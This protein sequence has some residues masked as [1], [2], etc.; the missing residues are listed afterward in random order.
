MSK[1]AKTSAVVLALLLASAARAQESRPAVSLERVQATFRSADRD[2]DRSITP[3]EAS[4]AGIPIR[5]FVRH[6]A[7]RDRRLS[8]DE[9]LLYYRYLLV[10]AGRSVSVSLETEASRIEGGRQKRPQPAGPKPRSSG[11][12]DAGTRAPEPGAPPNEVKP[13]DQ[14]DSGLLSTNERLRQARA[15]L[16]S[17][18]RTP[19]RPSGSGADGLAAERLRQRS[20]ELR[21]QAPAPDALAAG[22]AD[23]PYSRSLAVIQR[24]VNGGL[25]STQEARHFHEVLAAG[26]NLDDPGRA[27]IL[28]A[29]GKA[30][31]ELR[32]RLQAGD[33]TPEEARALNDQLEARVQVAMGNSPAGDARGGADADARIAAARAEAE[34][35]RLEDER[36]RAAVA[37]GPTQLSTQASDPPPVELSP[38]TTPDPGAPYQRSLAVI[39]RLV[40]GGLMGA[41]EARDFYSILGATGNL[42]DGQ[43]AQIL[44]A[45]G[46]ARTEIR[47]RIEA[48][49]LSTTEARE[50]T[51]LLESRV[52]AVAG[53]TNQPEEPRAADPQP[54]KPQPARLTPKP[55][56]RGEQPTPV[57]GAN[58]PADKPAR[59]TPDGRARDAKAPK[60]PPKDPKKKQQARPKE[61]GA[62]KGDGGRGKPDGR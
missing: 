33:L 51:A 29:L 59:P 52:Q 20:A 19:N 2:Q 49:D 32:A 18:A 21:A 30:R 44:V 36:R 23:A 26:G 56:D 54:A 60:D 9:F 11:S 53:R 3:R 62:D 46:R 1:Q 35:K 27:R 28:V 55:G 15:A 10:K 24:L 45:L 17:S 34:R 22:T 39:Q 31:A 7:D 43:R 12:P 47:S 13:A 40:Q 57:R 38:G 61:S 8:S 25:M 48:G 5:D 42:N 6:D 37:S 58:K 41:P 14:R 50:L 4:R 16:S